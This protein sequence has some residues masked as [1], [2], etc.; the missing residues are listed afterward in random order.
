TPLYFPIA[1]TIKTPAPM[2]ALLLSVLMIRPRNLLTP[3]GGIALVLLVFSLNCRVQI[4][5]RFMFTLMAVTYIAL[6]AAV[7]RT[8]SLRTQDSGL[9]TENPD[10]GTL[11]TRH[12]VLSSRYIP[13]W[14]VG[15]LLA[16][17]AGTSAWIW[18]HGLGYINQLWGGVEHGYRHLSDSN[19]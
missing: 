15:I 12:S 14:F 7:A 10:G 6:A 13:R 17:M 1:L 18:P 16:V 8:W 2:L 11:S 19:Y 3:L 9:R 4:G 5:I